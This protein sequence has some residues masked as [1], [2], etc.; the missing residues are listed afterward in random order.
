MKV[1][2]NSFYNNLYTSE[3]TENMH[4]VLESVPCKMT[5]QMN[6]MLNAPYTTEE[7]KI[8]LFQMAPQKARG[9]DGLPA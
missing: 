7:V 8:A 2:T 3:G 1:M 4:E 5:Q 9:S 6:E